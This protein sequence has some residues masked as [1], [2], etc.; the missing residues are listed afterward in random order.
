MSFTIPAEMITPP[1]VLVQ[2]SVVTGRSHTVEWPQDAD[3]TVHILVDGVERGVVP[4]IPAPVPV[5]VPPPT[6]TQLFGV[7]N[8]EGWGTGDI[9]AA[10]SACGITVD[11]YE[12]WDAGRLS[13]L[14][15]A[16]VD[17][18][19][20]VDDQTPMSQLTPSTYASRVAGLVKQYPAQV[21]WELLNE[22]Y[23]WWYR[24]GDN[25]P[26]SY[27][28]ICRAA[29]VAGK[30]ANPKARFFVGLRNIGLNVNLKD[31]STISGQEWNSRVLA[32][33]P[34][35]FQLADGFTAHAYDSVA[36]IF[37][38]LD[39]TKA[40]A[41]SQSGGSGKPFWV[42][43][44]NLPSSSTEA[45]VAAAMGPL[46]QGVKARSWIEAFLAYAWHDS[47]AAFSFTD[48]SRVAKQPRCGNFKAAVLA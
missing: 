22:P 29:V 14:A 2:P 30:A 36:N 47:T 6:T 31:G 19:A 40:W 35:L 5:P 12:W 17:F 24:G 16:G 38:Q 4:P 21:R 46:I 32:A 13:A 8:V 28:K 34:D 44:C 48:S 20:L 33:A 45:Q 43:E 1:S 15:S 18:I 7:T 41:W 37:A 23:G 3:G 10:K 9:T 25:D 39:A 26:A 42:T 27:G 11:R